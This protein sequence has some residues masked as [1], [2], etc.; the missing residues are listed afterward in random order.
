MKGP[1]MPVL[2]TGRVGRTGTCCLDP[3]AANRL[4]E[5]LAVGPTCV[6][7]QGQVGV[8]VLEIDH[9]W[10]TVLKEDDIL[11]LRDEQVSLREAHGLPHEFAAACWKASDNLKC[12]NEEA[13]A[14]IRAYS[15]EFHAAGK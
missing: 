6:L 11:P 2:Y 15:I 1:I 8:R 9:P 12:T 14:A 13:R 3:D 5:V 7:A 4:V 10:S